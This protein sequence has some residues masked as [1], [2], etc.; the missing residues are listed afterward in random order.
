[1]AAVV[2]EERLTLRDETLVIGVDVDAGMPVLLGVRSWLELEEN[3]WLLD[4]T[5][6]L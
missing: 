1:M 4:I 6:E 3:G 2:A 5:L